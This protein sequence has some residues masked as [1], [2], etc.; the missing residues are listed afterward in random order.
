LEKTHF[1]TKCSKQASDFPRPFSS[2]GDRA[3]LALFCAQDTPPGVP[4]DPSRDSSPPRRWSA[5]SP[6]G[7][8]PDL[9][10]RASMAPCDSE[11]RSTLCD[12]RHLR[13][14]EPLESSILYHPPA[15][16]GRP[17][18]VHP[19]GCFLTARHSDPE[20]CF[21]FFPAVVDNLLLNKSSLALPVRK[22]IWAK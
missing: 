11:I 6:F 21:Q 8:P 15:L 20:A 22:P 4:L 1:L 2:T 18:Q 13:K 12:C 7:S 17:V 16:G 14:P 9:T 10:I 3:F 5:S 19:T